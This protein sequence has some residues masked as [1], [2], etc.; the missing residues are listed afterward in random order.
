MKGIERLGD[1]YVSQMLRHIIS[2]ILIFVL[3]ILVNHTVACAW[4]ALTRLSSDTGHSWLDLNFV[5]QRTYD[6]FDATF[7]YLTAFHWSLT[8]MT[9]GSMPV[10]PTNSTERVFNIVCLFFGLLFFSSIISSI[11]TAFTQLKMLAAEREGLIS[12]LDTFLRQ[13][14]VSREVSIIVKK[15]VMTRM[16][17]RKPLDIGV[18][19]AL[20]W[21][22]ATMKEELLFDMC[23]HNLR[24]HQLFRLVE[25]TNNVVMKRICSRIEFKTLLSQDVLFV[26]DVKS[27]NA[28]LVTS[29]ILEYT[30]H[31][32]SSV[33]TQNLVDQD[34][35]S[36][37]RLTLFIVCVV[38]VVSHQLLDQEW[39]QVVACLCTTHTIIFL[40]SPLRQVSVPTWRLRDMDLFNTES[41]GSA[42]DHEA[43]IKVAL[44][45][46][47]WCLNPFHE[48]AGMPLSLH[49]ASAML[50]V[51]LGRL[52]GLSSS[53]P[54]RAALG[55]GRKRQVRC[56]LCRFREAS[57]FSSMTT[58]TSVVSKKLVKFMV[59]FPSLVSLPPLSIG[60][61]LAS[62]SF[63][64]KL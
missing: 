41:P 37:F 50:G 16:A 2:M 25:Q 19:K 32:G 59:G 52:V 33:L 61:L 45:V 63:P 47:L 3:L 34:R 5:N 56:G 30:Q 1:Q 62:V 22:S 53:M 15:Q 55:N 49:R 46:V 26:Q 24:S 44:E 28:Y 7:Q 57:V 27:D 21:L 39:W 40:P 64:Q 31:F 4:F 42:P 51:M 43:S 35:I 54:G 12:E 13:K 17:Q 9:P 10:Q 14:D 29:G 23:R 18:V 38:V 36:Q 60:P 6:D 11:T 58:C 20:S 48:A 8:Q